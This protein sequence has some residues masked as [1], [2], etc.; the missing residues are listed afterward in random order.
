[1]LELHRVSHGSIY[2]FLLF[3]IPLENCPK[4]QATEIFQR[5]YY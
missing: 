3:Y 1:M 2:R 5:D 4:Q